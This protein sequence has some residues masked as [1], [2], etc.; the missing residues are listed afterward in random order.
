MLSIITS[1]STIE[2]MCMRRPI[3]GFHSSL[4]PDACVKYFFFW[5][6][7]PTSIAI[8]VGIGIRV[9][10]RAI[11]VL[12]FKVFNHGYRGNSTIYL[13]LKYRGD[14]VQTYFRG[15]SIPRYIYLFLFL[16][17]FITR[18][19]ATFISTV[20]LLSNEVIILVILLRRS[21]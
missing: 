8:N 4:L 17:H 15:I 3:S 20:I 10:T 7:L 19:Y 21:M 13:T 12:L 2:H 18:I 11:V 1:T 9:L 14:G 5:I 16:W 6:E